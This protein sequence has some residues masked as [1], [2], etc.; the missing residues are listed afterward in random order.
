MM[1]ISTEN[2][3]VQRISSEEIKKILDSVKWMIDCELCILCIEWSM[4]K[5]RDLNEKLMDKKYKLQIS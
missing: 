2:Q 4:G 5:L 3:K 1:V